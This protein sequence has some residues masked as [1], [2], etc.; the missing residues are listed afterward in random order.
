MLLP[1]RLHLAFR[2]PAECPFYPLSGS[3]FARMHQGFLVWDFSS[4]YQLSHRFEESKTIGYSDF[5]N[6]A[7]LCTGQRYITLPREYT[8]WL[9][10]RIPPSPVA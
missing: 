4:N 7:D 5:M 9:S 1:C 8:L 3:T 10:C 6:K 2:T